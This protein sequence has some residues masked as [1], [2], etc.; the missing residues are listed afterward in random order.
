MKKKSLA[1]RLLVGL[2]SATMVLGFGSTVFAGQSSNDKEAI[3]KDTND[4]TNVKAAITKEILTGE[5]TALPKAAIFT[6]T[7]TPKT[8]G[9][10]VDKANSNTGTADIDMPASAQIMTSN[11]V[12]IPQVQIKIEDTSSVSAPNASYKWDNLTGTAGGTVG[13]QDTRLQ[14]YQ[15]QTG[16]FLSGINFTQAGIYVYTVKESGAEFTRGTI[17]T[18]E[19]T[20]YKSEAEYDIYLYVKE[21]SDKS[22]YYIYA[23][24]TVFTKQNGTPGSTYWEPA[25]NDKVDPT[26]KETPGTDG[27]VDVDN[28]ELTFINSF[29]R[30]TDDRNPEYNNLVLAKVRGANTADTTNKFPFELYL[31]QPMSSPI[32]ANGYRAY[33]LNASGTDVTSTAHHASAVN[34]PVTGNMYIPITMTAGGTSWIRNINLGFGERLV[35]KDIPVGTYFYTNETNTTVGGTTYDPTTAVKVGGTAITGETLTTASALNG[36]TRKTDEGENSVTTTNSADT[37]P[38]GII[39]NN[40]PFFLMIFIAAAALIL[41]A[42][43]R[44]RRRTA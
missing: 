14:R 18:G 13:S 33:V 15:L 26:P 42:V 4:E 2:L 12:D 44:G 21:K 34:D 27:K 36:A 1:K 29:E 23:M 24:G 37:P 9:T 38:T 8:S 17:N 3:V 16:D 28:S 30:K 5:T 41:Y 19:E 35:V 31:A 6:F 7:F 22:G 11:H 39:M 32:P 20:M 10:F 43:I 40:L 25:V